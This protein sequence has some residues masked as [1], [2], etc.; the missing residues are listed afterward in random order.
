MRLAAA[1]LVIAILAG[2][3]YA[4]L[5]FY[6]LSPTEK[7]APP[8]EVTIEKGESFRQIARAL[9]E[10]GVV[11]SELALRIYGRM[12]GTASQIKPGDGARARTDA[13]RRGRLPVPRDLQIFAAREDRRRAGGDA[14]AVLPGADA[15]GRRAHVRGRARRAP[16]GDDGVDRREGSEGAGRAPA[17]RRRVLQSAAAGDAAAIGSDGGVRTRRRQGIGRE[18]GPYDVGLQHLRL[19]RLAAGANRESGAQVDRGCAESGAD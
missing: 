13:A 14:R 1:I 9:A 5:S 17:N 7:F 12:S 11:R 8:R 6:W 16:A 15:A 18:C 19:Q 3:A 2:A 4:A 10:A